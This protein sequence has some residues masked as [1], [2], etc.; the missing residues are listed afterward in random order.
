MLLRN[1][2]LHYTHP[3]PRTV[4]ILWIAPEQS[5]AYVFDVDAKSSE[6]VQVALQELHADIA[7]GRA[8]RLHSDPYLV[9]LGRE[10]LPPK[11]LA[12]RTRAW[13]IIQALT[14]Q[15]PDIYDAR[16]R[17]QLI[18]LTTRLHG[19]SHPTIYR[20]LRRYWQR[21]QTPNALLP[22]YANSGGRGKVRAVS[23]GVKRGRPRKDGGAPGLNADGDIRRVFR[24]ATAHYAASHAKFSRRGAYLGMIRDFFSG[25]DA[26]PT[27]GQFIYWLDQDDDR[28]PS[29]QK[30]GVAGARKAGA[31][32][33]QVYAMGGHD[34][35]AVLNLPPLAGAGLPAARGLKL[36][37]VLT[38]P[39]GRPGSGFHLEQL[40]ACIELVDGAARAPAGR[41]LLTVVVDGFSRMVTGLH[42]GLQ[43]PA[44]PQALAALASSGMDKQRYCRE[45][46]RAIDAD[47]WPCQHL[48]ETL[49]APPPLAAS[50]AGD[51]TLLNNFNL[52]CLPCE[53]APDDWRA[54]LEKRVRLAPA[55]ESIA[56]GSRLDGV[57]DLVQFTRVVI[58]AVIYYNNRHPLPHAGGATPRQLWEWGVSHR[59]GA[60]RTYAEPL[61]RFALLAG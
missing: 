43:G 34:A 19:V 16:L 52:R 23:D 61:L 26:V 58:E 27:F 2:L 30:R 36:A 18:S 57:L 40:Q 4:R 9:V 50:G 10:P 24:V 46:G 3:S 51:D 54:V 21:G 5:H 22:D 14:Q 15:E 7:A 37:P 53:A 8:R 59:G 47:E 41:P 28:P 48:P 38:L 25:A 20:Y 49:Y 39:V 29:V 60:L 33:Q 35:A 56:H 44:W 45:F 31:R 6:V 17:G 32:Q 12:L 42:V 13:N 55:G 11:H 1:D